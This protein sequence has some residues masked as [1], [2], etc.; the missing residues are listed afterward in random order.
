MQKKNPFPLSR[1]NSIVVRT[2]GKTTTDR[3]K[4]TAIRSRGQL[5]QNHGIHECRKIE[6]KEVP[7]R[8]QYQFE[9]E[10]VGSTLRLRAGLHGGVLVAHEGVVVVAHGGRNPMP[11]S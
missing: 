2:G 8:K 1:T 7:S 4:D 10:N 6:Q 11:A 3:A 9:L 5:K